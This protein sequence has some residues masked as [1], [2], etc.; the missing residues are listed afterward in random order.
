MKQSSRETIVSLEK[1]VANLIASYSVNEYE[2]LLHNELGRQDDFAI[3]IEDYNMAKILGGEIFVSGK[4]RDANWN[5]VDYNPDNKEHKKQVEE[6]YYSDKHDITS[7]SGEKLGAISIYISNHSM[8]RELNKIITGTLINAATISLVL[9]LTLLITIRIFIL[10]PISSIITIISNSD[11]DGIPLELIPKHGSSEMLA[12]SKTMNNMIVSIRESR[13]TLN[14]QHNELLARK[15]QLSTLSM[16]TEQS[17]VSI[18]ICS[19]DNVIEYTNPQ[20]E[21]TSGFT[22]GEVVGRSIEFLFQY[23]E[24]DHEQYSFLNNALVLGEKWF[25]EISP[26]TKQDEEYS[27][28]MSASPITLDDGTISHNIYVAEDITE[29]KRNELILRNSQKMDAVGQLTG[30]I[31]HDFNNLLGIIMGNLELLEMELGDQPKLLERIEQALAGTA[32]GAQLTRKLLNFSRQD[33]HIK[34]LTQINPFIENIQEIIAK[35]VTAS[36]QV[37]TNLAENLWPVEIDQGELQD[38]I[39]NLSLNARDAMPNGGLLMIETSNKHLDASFV[40][41]HPSVSVGDYVRI[42]VSDN[43]IGISE[44]TEKKIYDPFYTTKAFGKGS[45]LGLSMVYGFVQRSGGYIQLYSEVGKGSSFSI[46]LPRVKN[47]DN[48]VKADEHSELPQGKE[49]ILIVDDEK[50]LTDT[51][52][53]YLQR[54]GYKTHIANSGKEALDILSTTDDIDLVFSDVVMPGI[55]GFE[56]AFSVFVKWPNI[57]VLLTSGFSAR[58]T[59]LAN[60]DEEVFIKLVENLLEKPYN[61]RE[62]ALA[63]R[64]TL[65]ENMLALQ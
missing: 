6:C 22:N 12:L 14:E 13:I 34:E 59:E 58:R 28:R 5:I 16:A 64:K 54:L 33:E 53:V 37:E 65:D 26:L 49:T 24:K 15:D 4:I 35:S 46:Y 3:V 31:A 38:A 1:N 39:L 21:K 63:V 17:P 20:F 8:N 27:L 61:M 51:S 44:E 42:C 36:I 52:R 7:D 60:L 9:I 45:G 23:R 43:G 50:T 19:D 18:L 29:L 30:G 2:N 40:N 41:R 11:D 55:D 25:G 56:L 57:K 48:E 32:R 10:K 62:L 47:K